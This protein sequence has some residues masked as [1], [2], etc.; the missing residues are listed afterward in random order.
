MLEGL[1]AETTD[2]LENLRDLARGIYPQLLADKD[3]PRRW[4]RRRGKASIPVHV[5]GVDRYP[6][7]IESALYF[8]CLEAL[9]NVAKYA[10]RVDLRLS[11][12]VDELEFELRDDGRG[13]TGARRSEEAAS[14]AWPTGSRPSAAG[15]RSARYRGR[16]RRWPAASPS[17]IRSARRGKRRAVQDSRWILSGGLPRTPVQ[18]P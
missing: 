15:S 6:Q 12:S 17:A 8:C 3:W 7:E 14:R 10:T 1:Q 11:E 18:R 5:D 9:Q 4:A 13:S 16:G 2:A